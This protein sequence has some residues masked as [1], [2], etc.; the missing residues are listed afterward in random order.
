MNNILGENIVRL[1]KEKGMTQEDL[2]K[3]L[4]ISYQAVSKWENG[5]SSPDISNIMLL[6]QFFGVSID[7]LFGLELIPE[8]QIISPDAEEAAERVMEKAEPGELS[9]PL[10]PFQQEMRSC[11]REIAES[12]F[13]WEDDSTL[14]AVLFRGRSLISAQEIKQ[15]GLARDIKLEYSGEA[16]N[17]FSFFDVSC[18]NVRG[19]VEAGGDVS[20]EAV[21]GFVSAKGDVNCG[22][23][24]ESV[25]CE[26]DADCG[27][28][29]RDVRAGGDVD[30]GE[31]GGSVTA[32]GDVD[33]G[34]V[35]GSVT[36]GGDVDCGDVSGSV[37]R[38]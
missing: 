1:R 29:G 14:R 28:V 36:S 34:D 15:S 10:T 26:G 3:E 6:A 24:G 17:V 38:R 4:N 31:V 9:A 35:S 11:E 8:E 25:N 12:D 18:E 7:M 33:C 32:G 37:I 16:L 22:D 20:C 19:C 21:G 13:L 27:D 30:C 2:A 23:V 5:V